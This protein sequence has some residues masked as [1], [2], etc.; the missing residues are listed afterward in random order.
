MDSKHPQSTLDIA[1]TRPITPCLWF[2]DQAESAAEFYVSMFSA[3]SILATSHYPEF[4]DNPGG[5]PRGSVL[6]VEFELAGQRF[7]ALNGGPIFRVNPSIS[8]FVF[9]DAAADA[10][11]LASRLA[12]GGQELMPLGEYPWSQRYG[13]VQDRFGV[14]WQIMLGGRPQTGAKIAPCLMFAGSVHGKAEAALQRYANIFENARIDSIEHYGAGEG[15]ENTVKHG[16]L[17]VGAQTLIA[18]DSHVEHGFTFNEAVSL[19]VVC[20]S[21]REIDKYWDALSEGGEQGP[22][23]WLK[24]RFGVSWQIVPK[25]I[26]EWMTSRDTAARDRAFHAVMGMKK[27]DIATIRTAF[28][29]YGVLI[30]KRGGSGHRPTDGSCLTAA[31]PA[32]SGWI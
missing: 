21:Q 18:M 7:T 19:Q 20:E 27:L 6:T 1:T 29:G 17:S 3:G 25:G 8:F 28:E 11:S 23:G 4:S 32:A 14:S 30:A 2:D 22:C 13:W 5:K 9:V 16:R 10:D 15:P 26:A 31:F 12:V 24:D